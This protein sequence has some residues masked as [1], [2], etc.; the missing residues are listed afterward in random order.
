[1]TSGTLKPPPISTAS[2]RE[3]ITSP[4]SPASALNVKRAA[5]ALLFTAIPDSAP[6]TILSNEPTC[7]CRDPL[8]PVRCRIRGLNSPVLRVVQPAP[9]HR[10]AVLAQG[11]CAE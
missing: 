8:V 7:E 9:H 1:M 2:L 10:S 5:A 4:P 11:S 3:T 6:D